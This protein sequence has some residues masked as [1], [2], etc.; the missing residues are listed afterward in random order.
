MI[1]EKNE[2]SDHTWELYPRERSTMT[3]A[4]VGKRYYG[5]NNVSAKLND[6]HRKYS[7]ALM[8]FYVCNGKQSENKDI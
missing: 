5:I 1:I 8:W 2:H 3:A 6:I 4:C 7:G